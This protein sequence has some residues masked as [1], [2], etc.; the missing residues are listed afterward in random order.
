KEH[1]L[2]CVAHI[3]NLVTQQIMYGTNL[4]AFEEDG[5]DPVQLEIELKRW[6]RKGA[7]SKLCNIIYWI[8]EKH[9]DG[10]QSWQFKKIQSEQPQL[11]ECRKKKLPTELKRPNDMH[12]NLHYYAF[13]AAI[14]NCPS[15]DDYSAQETR[16]Y[17]KLLDQ[18]REKNWI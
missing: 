7:L 14:C 11:D 18:T 15:I 5:E 13:E 17:N 16:L 2:R 10:G 6:R 9:A 3:F 12:W 4:L 8:T 1:R